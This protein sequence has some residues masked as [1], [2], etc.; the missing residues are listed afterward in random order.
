MISSHYEDL[1]SR[2]HGPVYPIPPAFNKDLSLDNKSI[3]SYVEF[4]NSNNIRAIM[5]T[6]GTSR[7]NLLTNEE[8][9]DFSKT[10]IET[11]R[12]KAVTIAA[13][14]IIGST[15]ETIEFC[16]VLEKL[17]TDAVLLYYPERYYNDDYIYQYVKEIA[18]SL[19]I[20]VLLH[21]VPMRN[22]RVTGIPYVP[23]SL[24]LCMRLAEINNFVGMKEESGDQNLVYKLGVHLG[25]KLVIIIAGA[26]MRSFMGVKNFGI[27]AFLTGIGSFKPE[28]EEN[29]YKAILTKDNISA[30]RYITKFEEPFF[31]VAFPMGWHV[32]M[33]GTMELLNI[34]PA[35]ER[36]PLKSIDDKDRKELEL[37][38]KR[39][40]WI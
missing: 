29:F 34:M 37:L 36:H 10:V 24:D 4:L 8:I 40:G 23:Y 18:N 12:G 22:G 1:Y 13:N 32:A 2:I 38:L 35:Y 6:A 28:I 30:L 14:P 21:T 31:D 9:L 20:A 19:R 7:F 33:K 15:K 11:N 16:K 26:A 3:S 5:L 25:D 39:F 17:G 27:R